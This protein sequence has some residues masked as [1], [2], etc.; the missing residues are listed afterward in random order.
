MGEGR[1]RMEEGEICKGKGRGTT[2][3]FQ[4]GRKVDGKTLEGKVRNRRRISR[5]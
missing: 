2:R 3:E 5:K 1:S 4:K